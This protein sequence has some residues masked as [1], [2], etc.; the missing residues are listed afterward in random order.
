MVSSQYSILVKPSLAEWPKKT[1]V[2]WL[3]SRP[4]SSLIPLNQPFTG[5]TPQEAKANLMEAVAWYIEASADC[6]S[7]RFDETLS[8]VAS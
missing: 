8:P 5:S 6:G 2:A 1:Y 3:T 7:E 4:V